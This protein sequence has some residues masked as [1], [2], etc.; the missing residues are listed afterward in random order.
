ML[1][2]V[3]DRNFDLEVIKFLIKKVEWVLVLLLMVVENVCN[4]GLNLVV[5]YM[6]IVEIGVDDDYEDDLLLLMNL[7]NFGVFIEF[8]LYG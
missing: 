8:V 5:L 1:Q 2:Q 7:Y 3:L 4:L 6:E